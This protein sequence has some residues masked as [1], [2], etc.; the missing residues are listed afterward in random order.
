M[1]K[2]KKSE[3]A[4]SAKSSPKKSAPEKKAPEK[5]AAARKPAPGGSTMI[6]TDFAA[7]AAARMLMAK[8]SGAQLNTTVDKKESSAFKQ[9]KDNL[10]NP[11]LTS[12]DTMLN[13]TAAPGASKSPLHQ[14]N[15][16]GH[17]QTYNADVTRTGVPRR[18]PG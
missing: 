17:Q 5:K 10:A 8:K 4:A 15:Q 14:Q 18:T 12:M 9:L 11:H 3:P 1:A 2:A 6:N 16:K 13:S 7:Q